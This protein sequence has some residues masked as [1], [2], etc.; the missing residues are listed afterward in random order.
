MVTPPRR[1]TSKLLKNLSGKNLLWFALSSVLAGILLL[2]TGH[3]KS[4]RCDWE[5]ELYCADAGFAETALG[6]ILGIMAITL[7]AAMFAWRFARATKR[8][9]T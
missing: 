3:L 4:I 2:V 5:A 6:A 7:L 8:P 9:T 1:F